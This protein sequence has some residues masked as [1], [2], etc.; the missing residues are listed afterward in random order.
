[1][2]LFKYENF[3]LNIAEEAFLLKPFKIIWN[4][5]KTIYKERALAELGYIY[6]LCDPRS[7]YMFL[8]DEEER[9]AKIIE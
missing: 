6:F 8:T 5:D 4:R 3:K 9:S 1:M 2:K 7:D